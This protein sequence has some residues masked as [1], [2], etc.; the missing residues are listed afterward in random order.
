MSFRETPELTEDWWRPIATLR[1][2]AP[3]LTHRSGIHFRPEDEGAGP[4]LL[5]VLE[6]SHSRQHFMLRNEVPH[7][8]WGTTVLAPGRVP[9]AETAWRELFQAL[10]V[11]DGEF[12]LS[13]EL[14]S[15]QSPHRVH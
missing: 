2:D 5:A 15:G 14:K 12:E 10:E 8:E 3:D 6:L 1:L 4:H 7:P 11:R 9:P 13:P